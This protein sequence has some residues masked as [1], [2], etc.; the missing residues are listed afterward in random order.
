[1][2]GSTPTCSAVRSPL[3]SNKA[4]RAIR[5]P[6]VKIDPRSLLLLLLTVLPARAQDAA[7]V[8]SVTVTGTRE[9]QVIDTFVKSLAAPAPLSGKI[10]RWEDGVCPITVGLRPAA[11]KFVSDRLRAVARDVG[12]PVGRDGCTPNVEI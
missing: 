11:T 1:M 10:T 6:A 8:E 12:A 2:A 3:P 7:S 9:R 5:G 4:F